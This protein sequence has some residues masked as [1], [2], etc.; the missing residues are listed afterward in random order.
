MIRLRDVTV[1]RGSNPVVSGLTVEIDAGRIF[2]I[3]GA[4]G[5]GKSSLL[6]VLVGLDLPRTGTISRLPPEPRLLYFGSD[7][8]LPPAS[9]VGDWER[10]LERLS[11]GHGWGGRT[12]LWPMVPGRRRVA[13]LSTGER[14]RLLLDALLRQSGPVALDEP[15][16]H[17]SPEAKVE[18]RSLLEARAREHLVIVATNQG[19]ERA[20]Q[21][22]GLR[23]EGGSATPL[24]PGAATL[25]PGGYVRRR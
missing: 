6:R 23:L 20:R 1:A 15:F 21:D 22:G 17:I 9:T 24:G 16:E 3:I 12:P 8:T 4:N 2:W 10:L 14:K 7:M 25:P 13:R 18:L 5:A 11:R 19:V